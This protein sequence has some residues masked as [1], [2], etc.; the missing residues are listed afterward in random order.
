MFCLIFP[1]GMDLSDIV[2]DDDFVITF[3]MFLTVVIVINACFTVTLN[4]FFAQQ[5]D[6]FICY[7]TLTCSL[8][9]T[10]QIR[11]WILCTSILSMTTTSNKYNNQMRKYMILL[12][13]YKIHAQ[14]ISK[15]DSPVDHALNEGKV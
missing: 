11:N 5:L 10:Q 8:F 7:L 9:R 1:F 2:L 14:Q 4:N 15:N 12:V 3:R 13:R 6:C